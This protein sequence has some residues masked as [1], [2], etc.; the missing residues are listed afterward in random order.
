MSRNLEIL[1]MKN[2]WITKHGTLSTRKVCSMLLNIYW[3]K[4]VAN[5]LKIAGLSVWIIQSG[6]QWAGWSG[7]WRGLNEL[8]W[9]FIDIYPGSSAG[10]L[11]AGWWQWPGPAQIWARRNHAAEWTLD[12]ST[13]SHAA[14][15][16]WPGPVSPMHSCSLNLVSSF[17]LDNIKLFR[18][19]TWGQWCGK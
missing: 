8:L 10:R 15:F 4:K 6:V 13:P 18:Y 9:K 12:T 2:W 7:G 19:R 3:I 16:L 14:L 1:D 5:I 11:V 17:F